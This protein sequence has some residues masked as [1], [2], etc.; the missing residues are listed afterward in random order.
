MSTIQTNQM[1]AKRLEEIVHFSLSD[2]TPP[3][4]THTQV[5][6]RESSICRTSIWFMALTELEVGGEKQV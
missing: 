5:Y 3:L 1:I 2:N 4:N 6:C